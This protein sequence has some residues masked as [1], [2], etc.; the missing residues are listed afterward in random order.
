MGSK[1]YLLFSFDKL[2]IQTAKQLLSVANDDSSQKSIR[3]FHRFVKNMESNK[4]SGN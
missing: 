1:A 2:I 3:M 4:S